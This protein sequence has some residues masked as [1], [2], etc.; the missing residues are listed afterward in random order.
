[1]SE[2][3][4]GEPTPGA[5]GQGLTVRRA[6]PEDLDAIMAVETRAHHHP[7]QRESFAREFTLEW[8]RIWVVCAD[9]EIAGFLA[10]WR[11]L[12]E[13]HILDVAV[14]PDFQR[15]GIARALLQMLLALGQAH[16][17]VAVLLEVRVS[18]APALG[19]YK[20]L[21][22]KRMGRRKRYYEDGEDAWVMC[23]ELG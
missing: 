9:D 21:G 15:R 8:S 20:S 10:F 17:V 6:R 14:H 5:F 12:D 3:S 2:E 4:W 11:V 22:F 1:M 19:L 23:A 7:W 18:N 13:L 16:E